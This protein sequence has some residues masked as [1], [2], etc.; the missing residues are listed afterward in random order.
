MAIYGNVIQRLTIQVYTF[1][2][3]TI[4]FDFFLSSKQAVSLKMSLVQLVLAIRVCMC[5][6]MRGKR[7]KRIRMSNTPCTK[8]ESCH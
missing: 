5:T 1:K 7:F 3:V 8:I 4:R 6:I 2:H